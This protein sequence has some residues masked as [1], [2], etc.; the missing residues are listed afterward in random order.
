[1]TKIATEGAPKLSAQQK[2]SCTDCN[3]ARKPRISPLGTI[4]AALTGTGH[5][6]LIKR[7]QRRN[8]RGKAGRRGGRR[9]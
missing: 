2:C 3:A 7:L 4:V 5:D 1:V 9:G 6:R 8:S